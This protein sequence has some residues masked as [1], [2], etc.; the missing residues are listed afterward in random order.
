[1]KFPVIDESSRI[2]LEYRKLPPPGF[3]D[4]LWNESRLA[5]DQNDRD[6]RTFGDFAFARNTKT[7]TESRI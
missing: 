3:Q 5:L 4:T 7:R 6:R 2:A 1:V